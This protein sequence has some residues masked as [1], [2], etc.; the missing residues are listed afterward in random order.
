VYVVNVAGG[1]KVIGTTWLKQLGAHIVDY[2]NSF[3]RFLHE[4]AFV[5]IFGENARMPAQAQYNHIKCLVHID[6]RVETYVIQV[7]QKEEE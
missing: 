7:Q 6:A 1:D 3:I 4:G 2:Q 5:T